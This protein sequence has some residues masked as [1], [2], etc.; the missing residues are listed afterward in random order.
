MRAYVGVIRLA[1]F[2]SRHRLIRLRKD[3]SVLPT[4]Y[5]I[6]TDNGTFYLPFYCTI[7]HSKF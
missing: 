6:V 1:G 7:L 3:L 2:H 5:Y 4:I